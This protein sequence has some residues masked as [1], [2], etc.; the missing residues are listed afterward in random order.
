MSSFAERNNPDFVI[1]KGYL[2]RK[3]LSMATIIR[4]KRYD[5]NRYFDLSPNPLPR[6][7][8]YTNYAQQRRSS[9]KKQQESM[10]H[11]IIRALYDRVNN[12]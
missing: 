1:T 3:A 11:R 6:S 9:N 12:P 7:E 10:H 2:K 8:L 4:M 5:S